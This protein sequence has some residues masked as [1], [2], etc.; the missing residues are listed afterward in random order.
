M[1]RYTVPIM[2]L[3]T[4]LLIIRFPAPQ[5]EVLPSADVDGVNELPLLV[6]DC[7]DG[8][9]VGGRS[10]AWEWQVTVSLLTLQETDAEELS[11]QL[12]GYMHELH[13]NGAAIPGVGMISSV[14]DVFMPARRAT[15]KLA[16]GDLT[17]YDG[18]WSVIVRKC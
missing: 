15:T 18:T 9:M 2:E 5:F 6:L 10:L 1:T 8:H 14:D 4:K 16:A 7:H 3:M 17:Q 12:Y 11:D 13:D